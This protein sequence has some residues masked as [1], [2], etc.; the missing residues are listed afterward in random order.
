[1]KR[2][3]YDRYGNRKYTN[4]RERRRFLRAAKTTATPSVYTFCLVLAL[5]GARISEVLAL[6]P[7][8]IDTDARCIVFRTLKQKEGEDEDPIYRPVPVP[9]RV[10][11][12]LNAVHDVIA[13]QYDE[14]RAGTRIWSWSRTTAWTRVK[15]VMQTAGITGV[16]G[17]PKGLRHGFTVG[18]LVRGVPE[19]TVCLWLGHSSLETT[20]HYAE[21][22]GAEARWIA[23]RMWG[24][25]WRLG[26]W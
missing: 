15:E 12:E 7:Q 20:M 19:M 21:A 18:A 17:T 4:A 16:H 23:H 9:R 14:T 5:T 13:A 24:W 3:L 26:F 11:R 10:I 6:T 1:M 2:R 22:I 25:R 8:N